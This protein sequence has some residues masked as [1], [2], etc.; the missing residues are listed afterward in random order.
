MENTSHC[1]VI[2]AS[3][4]RLVAFALALGPVLAAGVAWAATGSAPVSRTGSASVTVVRPI[5]VSS[6]AVMSF[7]KAVAT[8]ND[9]FGYVT[10]QAAP[11][12]TLTTQA[13]SLAG[14]GPN[15]SPL[16]LTVT[17]EPGRAYRISLPLSAASNPGAFVVS[18]FTMWTQNS[19]DVTTTK[20]AYFSAQGSDTVRVGGR[21]AIP[22]AA[23]AQSYTAQVPVTIS[24]E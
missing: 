1:K 19:G 2:H 12:T 11:P 10:L 4:L 18:N 8:G 17:G 6:T 13:A 16:V 24:Y 23:K 7:G 9:P 15:P 5:T 20:L 21:I 14:G 22:H 3:R